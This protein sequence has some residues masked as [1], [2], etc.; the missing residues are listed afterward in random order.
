M[1]SNDITYTITLTILFFDGLIHCI[2]TI[3]AI[4]KTVA[5][6][7]WAFGFTHI[8]HPTKSCMSFNRFG[9]VQRH[10]RGRGMTVHV[11]QDIMCATATPGISSTASATTNMTK[12]MHP[13]VGG[14]PSTLFFLKTGQY[15]FSWFVDGHFTIPRTTINTV[16]T[17]RQTIARES[18]DREEIVGQGQAWGCVFA[19][20]PYVF[21]ICLQPFYSFLL[22]LVLFP[23]PR[24]LACFFFLFSSRH[25]VRLFDFSAVV[26]GESFILPSLSFSIGFSGVRAQFFGW[27][28]DSAR[29]SF[30]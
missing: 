2:T 15:S 20:Q 9:D 11:G 14:S 16:R 8:C 12:R 27:G 10:A 18:F 23:L 29:C 4:S 26:A 6:S 1:E 28:T 21:V 24:L 7:H 5:H 19:I 17:S 22:Q 30:L 3:A 25:S 13:L